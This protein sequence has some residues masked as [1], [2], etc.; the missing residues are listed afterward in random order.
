MG[1]FSI[2]CQLPYTLIINSLE[3]AANIIL[4]KCETS[5]SS[6]ILLDIMNVT[7]L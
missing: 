1:T 5:K 6:I 2:E 7:A 3:G 4:T